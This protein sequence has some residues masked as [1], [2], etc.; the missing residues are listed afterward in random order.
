MALTSSGQRRTPVRLQEP[1]PTATGAIDGY[2]PDGVGGYS[3]E[4][5]DLDPPDAFV[6]VRAATPADQLRVRPG[7][8]ASAAATH[9]LT[10]P[11]HPGMTVRTVITMGA[12]TLSVLGYDDPE[13]RHIETVAYCAEVQP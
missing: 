12:R 6:A 4:L 1:S 10:M 11:Y 8:I 2:V 3:V 13:E 9:V 7:T 5:R